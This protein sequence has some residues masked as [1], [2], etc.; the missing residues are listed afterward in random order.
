MEEVEEE[1]EGDGE[2]SLEDDAESDE[3]ED[4]EGDEEVDEGAAAWLRWGTAEEKTKVWERE[5][6]VVRTVARTGG[7]MWQEVVAAWQLW[8]AE[9]RR[10]WSGP[11]EAMAWA[12]AEWA[13]WRVVEEE[14]DWMA[15][16]RAS[17][18]AHRRRD[19]EEAELW[20]ER[21]AERRRARGEW[22]PEETGEAE[23][24]RRQN[25]AEDMLV[26]LWGAVM[27][28][29]ERRRAWRAAAMVMGRR[30]RGEEVAVVA[31]VGWME[32]QQ[33]FWR[34]QSRDE[35]W[36]RLHWDEWAVGV[37]RRLLEEWEEAEAVEE[38]ARRALRQ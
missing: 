15:H 3:E 32:W 25:R 1:V 30:R 24:K 10:R 28:M 23:V 8:W 11:Q 33:R 9:A 12:A 34:W 18:E 6:E 22:G 4:G 19:E 26:G 21:E 38:A 5:V 29:V 2:E 13:I 14:E 20:V 16:M 7:W 35:F 37:G 17:R 27:R 31:L 36:W